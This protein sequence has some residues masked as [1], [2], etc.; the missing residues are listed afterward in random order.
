MKVKEFKLEH[1]GNINSMI[2]KICFRYKHVVKLERGMT[3]KGA[4]KMIHKDV[5]GSGLF[6]L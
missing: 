6:E 5:S 2:N 3:G 4:K 1:Q